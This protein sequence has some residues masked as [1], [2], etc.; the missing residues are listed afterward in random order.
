VP[1]HSW[2]L[3]F[4]AAQHQVASA[5]TTDHAGH[6]YLAGTFEGVINLGGADLTSAGYQ[7]IFIACFDT[8][9]VHQWSQSFGDIDSD[10]CSALGTDGMGNLYAAGWFRETIDFGGGTLTC[11]GSIAAFLVKFSSAGV[12]V[13]SKSFGEAA[14]DVRPA[15]LAVDYSGNAYLS[16]GFSGGVNFGGGVLTSAGSSDVFLAKFNSAGTHQWSKRF[17]GSSIEQCNA[18]ALDAGGSV[19]YMAGD[20]G[21]LLDFGGGVLTQF[22]GYDVFLARFD[23]SGG[24]LWSKAFGSATGHDSAKSVAT[25]GAGRIYLAGEVT[26]TINFGGSDLTAGGGRDIFIAKFGPSG[27]HDWSRSFGDAQEQYVTAVAPVVDK[28]FLMGTLLGSVNFGGDDLTDAGYGDIYLAEFDWKGDHVW[29]QRFGDNQEQSYGAMVAGESS[30]LIL[31]GNFRGSVSFGG[32]DLVSSD[33]GFDQDVFLVRFDRKPCEP[34][35]ESVADVGND[36][37]RKVRI[38]FQQSGL[39]RVECATPITQ[40]EIYR[41][42]DPLPAGTVPTTATSR[43]QLEAAGWLLAGEIPAHGADV[44]MADAATDVDS[45]AIDGAYYSAF[46]IRTPTT[47][48]LVYYDSPIDSGCSVDNL[49]PGVPGGLMLADGILTWTAPNETDLGHFTIYGSATNCRCRAVLIE[50]TVMTTLDVTSHPYAYY[51]VTATDRSGNEG[52][53]AGAPVGAPNPLSVLSISSYPNPFN[54]STTIRCV[55]PHRGHVSLAIYDAGGALVTVLVDEDRDAGVKSVPWNGRDAAGSAVSS[56]V[57]F[58]QLR[59]DGETRSHKL[60]LLK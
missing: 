34:I 57:Y 20:F 48:P 60:L 45:T 3:G 56:G 5:T 37:G 13:W 2:S 28:V 26:G 4:L 21:G 52:E 58:A 8:L 1:A 40:Y 55:L 18:L 41:R 31:A 7:D 14:G 46:F 25:D 35:I 54:P 12:H 22:G 36:Q 47:N 59:H 17:G 43:A 9:G 24:H 23:A 44:Y 10:K 15:A 50:R 30:D 6:V 33:T 32:A 42:N 49:A 19:V 51:F 27:S 39:D 53:A 16:G 38:R 29:G 11:V